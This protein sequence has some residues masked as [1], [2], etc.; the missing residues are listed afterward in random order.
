M[1][2]VRALL[3]EHGLSRP[4]LTAARALRAAG[5]TV[6]VGSPRP[7]FASWSQTTERRHLLPS[8]ED[9][10]DPFIDG[11][12]R[13]IAEGGYEVVFG[14][15]DGELLALSFG[16]ERVDAI[17]PYPPHERVTRALDKVLLQEAARSVG[18]S[19]PRTVEDD[20]AIAAWEGPAIIKA[21]AH[22]DPETPGRTWHVPSEFAVDG[23]QALE[24]VRRIRVDGADPI[25]QEIVH[26]PL[27]AYVALLDDD[28]E[29]VAHSLQEADDLWPPQAGVTVHG[30]TLPVDDAV[31]EL[32]GRLLRELGWTGLAELQYLVSADGRMHLIDLNG[33]FYGSLALAVGAGVNLPHLWASL[34][35]GRAAEPVAAQSRPHVRYQW[36]EGDLRRAVSER[37]GGL[38]RDLR[39]TLGRS[40]GRVH[41]IW[42]PR[43]P[44][45]ALRYA[46][47]VV[48]RSARRPSGESARADRRA[49]AQTCAGVR[50]AAAAR[51][52]PRSPGA[53]GGEGGSDRRPGRGWI[54]EPGTRMGPLRRVH[55]RAGGARAGRVVALARGGARIALRRG[56]AG[57]VRSER[58]AACFP[59]HAAHTRATHRPGRARAT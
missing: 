58:R 9:G 8:V 45:P 2:G 30:R 15:G 57:G 53:R 50:L 39:A 56:T 10:L 22:A 13:A 31:A 1:N 32:G 52:R 33:R 42:S 41:S 49:R 34:A 46:Y 14:V 28:G 43:D 23:A 3:V 6:G 24:I 21:R 54:R 5:W 36:L 29:L 38:A 19:A 48:A 35:T 17:V 44:L 59:S 37:R 55:G 26:G 25:V 47:M 7:G 12:N 18:F 27:R 51:P 11:V 40:R 16:R 4:A 20:A